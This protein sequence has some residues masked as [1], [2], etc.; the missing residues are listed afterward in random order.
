MCSQSPPDQVLRSLAV[1]LVAHLL[2]PV[3]AF[4]VEM[5]INGDVRHRG[6]RRGTM[7]VLF[8]RLS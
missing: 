8:T 3:R 1:L 5:L 4:A 7:P 6:G 2:Q